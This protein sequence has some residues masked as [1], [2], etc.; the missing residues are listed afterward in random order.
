[1]LWDKLGWFLP[2]EG[3]FP[4]VNHESNKTDK[5]KRGEGE[6]EREIEGKKEGDCQIF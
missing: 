6:R 1:M 5:R 4:L 2:A 3:D